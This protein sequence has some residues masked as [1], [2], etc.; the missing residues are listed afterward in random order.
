[1][2]WWNGSS[3][4]SGTIS[5]TAPGSSTSYISGPMAYPYATAGS[6]TKIYPIGKGSNYS[7]LTLSF[8]QSAAIISIYT[9]ES[10]NT[11]PPAY[12]LPGSLDKV[13]IVRYYKISE[14]GSGS[15][16]TAGS[17]VLNYNVSDGVSDTT[18]LRIAQ[19]PGSGSG[20][21]TD[22]GGTASG[23]PTGK[24]TSTVSFA[25]LASYTIFTLANHTGGSNSLP[26]ELSS[27]TVSNKSRSNQINWITSTEK[28]CSKFDIER[29]LVKTNGESLKWV[30]SGTVTASGT[31]TSVR[32][33]SFTDKNLQVGKYQYRLKMI[34]YDGSFQYS[35]VVETEIALPKNFDLS[36]NYPNPFN[37]STKIDYTLP[38]DSKIILEVYNI[39]GA[40]VSQLVNEEQAPGYYS[41]EFNS[42]LIGKNIPSGV[43][44]YRLT[45]VD[46]STGHNYA[47]VKKMILL[48]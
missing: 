45:A 13:S 37:P 24:I 12:T 46:K 17:V 1:M 36:Q 48:K 31:S 42:S 19:G 23:S 22:I 3:V 30:T 5:A 32:S 14:S 27:F 20:T 8:T 6:T 44:L 40:M 47:Q 34:D 11:A 39:K 28:N 33:Y 7:P 2:G 35:N 43:Y 38:S 41:L 15:A 29:V 4:T 26:V 21:W 10:F 16:I 25:D 9:A 18:N